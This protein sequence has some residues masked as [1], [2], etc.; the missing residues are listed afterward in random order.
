MDK[1]IKLTAKQKAL[2][3]RL[4]ELLSR[5]GDE[6]IGILFD[7]ENNSLYFYNKS[8]VIGLEGGWGIGNDEWSVQDDKVWITPEYEELEEDCVNIPYD[9]YIDGDEQWF[10]LAV[11]PSTKA[12]IAAIQKQKDY[13]TEYKRKNLQNTIVECEAEKQRYLKKIDEVLAS[14]GLPQKGKDYQ[15]KLYTNLINKESPIIDPIHP[16]LSQPPRYT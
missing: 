4:K 3:K 16:V 12:E 6:N 10:A 5:I 14:E 7:K 13:M 9:E 1:R 2:I 15:K 11:A 8:N